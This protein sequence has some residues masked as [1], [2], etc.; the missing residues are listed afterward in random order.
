[1][2]FRTGRP[3][4]EVGQDMKYKQIVTSG[5]D[6]SRNNNVIINQKSRERQERIR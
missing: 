3:I 4:I 5:G 1:M 2:N 6:R